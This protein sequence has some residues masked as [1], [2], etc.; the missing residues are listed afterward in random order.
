MNISATASSPQALTSDTQDTQR[1]SKLADAAHQFEG[2]FLQQFLKPLQSG[3]NSLTGDSNGDK[4]SDDSDGSGDTLQTYGTEALANAISSRGG[5][6][7]ARQVIQ[8][9]TREH[10]QATQKNLSNP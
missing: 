7:I 5:F 4:S 3:K 9:V 1:Q 6:G 8:Q 10:Q 2:M